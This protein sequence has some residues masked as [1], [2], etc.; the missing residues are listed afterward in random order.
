MESMAR[1][2]DR[3]PQEVSCFY[4]CRVERSRSTK[5]RIHLQIYMEYPSNRPEIL[6]LEINPLPRLRDYLTGNFEIPAGS[7]ILSRQRERRAI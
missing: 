1:G 7:S 5:A 3:K 6:Q 2:I 4:G